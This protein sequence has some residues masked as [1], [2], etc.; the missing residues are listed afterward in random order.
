ME[1]SLATKNQ[2]RHQGQVW[3]G[4]RSITMLTKYENI[5]RN[6]E[7]K[8]TSFV[9]HIEGWSF[10]GCFILCIRLRTS[11][12]WDTPLL[13]PS[14]TKGLSI[15]SNKLFQNHVFF[16][17]KLKAPCTYSTSATTSH[18]NHWKVLGSGSSFF[19][20]AP[21]Y[22]VKNSKNL[23]TTPGTVGKQTILTFQ[24]V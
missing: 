12:R 11:G 10:S 15:G 19:D 13:A 7:E 24:S 21:S 16:G 22:C 20:W 1:N 8:L 3:R 5:F 23:G 6:S 9:I 2:Q 18:P 17:S 4:S 14:K